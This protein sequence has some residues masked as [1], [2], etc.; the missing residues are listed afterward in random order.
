MREH[1][2]ALASALLS[3]GLKIDA[4][5]VYKIAQDL[6]DPDRLFPTRSGDK[7][8][9]N[10]MENALAR[11]IWE[12]AGKVAKISFEDEKLRKGD[13]ITVADK[14]KIIMSAD[15][16]NDKFEIGISPNAS[17]EDIGGMHPDNFMNLVVGIFNTYFHQSSIPLDQESWIFWM[18]DLIEFYSERYFGSKIDEQAFAEK[19]DRWLEENPN[20]MKDESAMSEDLKG[21]Y[22]LGK[23]RTKGVSTPLEFDPMYEERTQEEIPTDILNFRSEEDDPTTRSELN[24]R[25]VKEEEGTEVV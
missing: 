2:I 19:V 15:F 3:R 22:F 18:T 9:V 10:I 20:P 21:L 17:L 5:N 23:Q 6:E 13:A 7:I 16:Y 25:R 24:K 14:E 4:D 12:Y 1:L 11:S 8:P